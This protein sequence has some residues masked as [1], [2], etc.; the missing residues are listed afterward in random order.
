MA[1]K[2]KRKTSFAF[3][4]VKGLRQY[5]TS[6]I[7]SGALVGRNG[8]ESLH[9]DVLARFKD[10]LAHMGERLTLARFT[11]FLREL[12]WTKKTQE[13][14]TDYL[15]HA[16]DP[17]AAL[18]RW[19][20]S[21]PTIPPEWVQ[22][23][24]KWVRGVSSAVTPVA[25][26]PGLG[27]YLERGWLRGI[28]DIQIPHSS[29]ERPYR[30]DLPK[31][32]G[33]QWLLLNGA[34]LGLV[35]NPVIEE[36]PLR[37]KL[38]EAEAH[39]ID[40]VFLTNVFALEV[41]KAQGALMV[42]RARLAGLNTN[43]ELLDPDYREEAKEIIANDPDD[44]V[45]FE[46]PVERMLNVFSG[47]HK[48]MTKPDG[49]PEFSGKIFMVLGYNDELL[50][51]T[52]TYWVLNYMRILKQQVLQAEIKL[53]KRDMTRALSVGDFEAHDVAHRE[54]R[55][56]VKQLARTTTTSI[57]NQ[58]V[59]RFAPKIRSLFLAKLKEFV[60]NVEVI[61]QGTTFVQLGDKPAITLHIPGHRRVTDSL[62]ASYAGKSGPKILRRE[63]TQTTVICHPYAIHARDTVREADRE[64][65]RR[66]VQIFVA[67]ILVDGRYL[68]EELR[69]VV[70]SVH[71]I[72][73]AIFHDQFKPGAL[74]F[75]YH[76][77]AHI[78]AQDFWPITRPMPIVHL[79]RKG[80]ERGAGQFPDFKSASYIWYSIATDQHWL[81]RNKEL[82][83]CE[84]RRE[85]LGMFEAVVHSMRVSGYLGSKKFGIHLWSS[86]DDPT[87]GNHF[88]T[89]L[90][91]HPHQLSNRE[92]EE[93]SRD[94]YLRAKRASGEERLRLFS[95][96]QKFA[97]QQF[98]LRGLDWPQHQIEELIDRHIAPNMDFFSS[99]LARA[100]SSGL[101]IRPVSEHYGLRHA[102]GRDLGIL[103]WGTGN[104]FEKSVER[105]LTEGFLYARITQEKLLQEARWAKDAE[106]VRKFVR[107]PLYS[108]FFCAWGTI[109]FPGGYEWGMDLRASPTRMA[110]WGDTL[111]G[112][113]RND[114]LRGNPTRIMDGRM[115]IQTYGDKHFFGTAVTPDAVFHMCASGTHTD[116]YGEHG[117]PPNNTG[118]SF[119][120][121]PAEGPRVPIL[122][123]YL[124]Y[125]QIVRLV[126]PG[127]TFDWEAFLPNPV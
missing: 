32:S 64:G 24:A 93:R 113:T 92:I 114:P 116:R 78:V 43:V 10:E 35:Y 108:N 66:S 104:H 65:R 119:I 70:R 109:M 5:L 2:A 12:V 34:N 1:V 115:R 41:V 8:I 107:A 16:R 103:N 117:F 73:R 36:N 95:E 6:A 54:M 33:C 99:V 28:P 91:P 120:G 124:R 11:K 39:G 7:E 19:Q 126:E 63:I 97:L 77:E 112:A 105:M 80:S 59:N 17:D 76:G 25:M 42:Y 45:V 68:R 100:R 81:S 69:D 15:R 101:I 96:Y 49:N 79:K 58:Q 121:I 22:E 46:S 56:L 102:D 60:P 82:V 83:W 94:L 30:V 118:V 31:G 50:I 110:G 75:R 18:K 3:A 88:R 55:K 48:I 62:L 51:N 61:G 20:E 74:R 122:F 106:F 52:L 29:F 125:D 14:L 86:N 123:R 72:Q 40:V 98:N 13:S 90:Q 26:I 71:P 47:L 85:N 38:A 87:Q 53:A 37:R 9:R 4:E 44:D 89:E 57:T 111:L 67:P 27:G 23:R 84:D 21:Y 127:A